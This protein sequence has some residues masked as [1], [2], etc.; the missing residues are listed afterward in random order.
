[1]FATHYLN[2]TPLAVVRTG[3]MSVVLALSLGGVFAPGLVQA[4]AMT[5]GTGPEF[6]DAAQRWLDASVASN[7]AANGTALRM[8]VVVGSLD[9]RLKLAPCSQVEPFVPVGTRLWGKT[10][11]GLR[12]LDAG[13]KW[14]VFL[15]VTVKAFGPA[16]VIK[17]NVMA[18][19][20]LTQADVME[21]EVDWAEE[22]SP[23]VGNP[24]QWLGQVATRALGTGQTL[25]QGMIKPALVFQAGAQIR[26]VAQGMGFQIS[27][28]AQAISGGVVGQLA[29]V[30]ME[31]GRVMSGLVVD[32]RTVRLEM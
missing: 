21:S 25:R 31:N 29:K 11:L 30:R 18:G 4:Q 13:V 22:T 19:A 5:S 7:R 1:M 6:L 27:S 16:W 14:N 9:S 3:L 20:A 15:P 17:G 10:R 24:A 23:V 12:C 8:E 2:K 28:D 32:A 26:V